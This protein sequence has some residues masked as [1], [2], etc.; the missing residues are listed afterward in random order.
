LN[1]E[2]DER[3]AHAGDRLLECVEG[4]VDR[5]EH[6]HRERDIALHQ[7]F[8]GID[9]EVGPVEGG[10]EVEVGLAMGRQRPRALGRWAAEVEPLEQRAARTHGFDGDIAAFDPFGHDLAVG[11]P[12]MADR[13]PPP[14]RAE[15]VEFHVGGVGQQ[16]FRGRP[17]H[18]VVERECVALSLQVAAGFH[19]LLVDFDVFAKLDDD[20]PGRQEQR[21]AAHQQGP[22]EVDEGQ[23][24]VSE[25][26]EADAE[27]GIGQH[28]RAGDVPFGGTGVVEGT[29]AVEQLVAEDV[30]VGVEDRLPGNMNG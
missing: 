12:Q 14:W 1:A 5:T 29:L 22:G 6:T 8:E 3:L 19:Q 9:G 13:V 15:D 7:F 4:R 23:R 26:V 21:R 25:C 27:Q 17:D 10:K 30:P 28:S 16:R 11:Q 2:Q 20:V 18:E 24:S